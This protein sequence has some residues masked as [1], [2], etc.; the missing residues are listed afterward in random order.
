MLR[1]TRNHVEIL[2][3]DLSKFEKSGEREKITN[4][5][6][7]S[8]RNE[9]IDKNKDPNLRFDEIRNENYKLSIGNID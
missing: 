1:I 9:Y 6:S 5:G 3:K 8:A 4:I 2:K 7:F